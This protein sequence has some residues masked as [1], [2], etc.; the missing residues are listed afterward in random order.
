[1]PDVLQ[2]HFRNRAPRI[3][4]IFTM[5]SLVI[6]FYAKDESVLYAMNAEVRGRGNPI[7]ALSAICAPRGWVVVDDSQQSVVDLSAA[8]SPEWTQFQRYRDNAIAS[9]TKRDNQRRS[10]L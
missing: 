4:G 1:M 9:I 6:Q 7:P 8:T 5:D 2:E 10:N 3:E